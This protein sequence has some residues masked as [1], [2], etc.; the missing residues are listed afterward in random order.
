MPMQVLLVEDS[1]GGRP[2]DAG[3]VPATLIRPSICMWL[4]MA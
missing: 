4:P 2:A 1:S 3:S